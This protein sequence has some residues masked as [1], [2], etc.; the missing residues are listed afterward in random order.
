MATQVRNPRANDLG[1]SGREVA[2]FFGSD[3]GS[4]PDEIWAICAKPVQ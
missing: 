4:P 1:R 3:S 2:R